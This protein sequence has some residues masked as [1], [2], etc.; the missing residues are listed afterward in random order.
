[1]NQCNAIKLFFYK[2]ASGSLVG[3]Q[4]QDVK[5]RMKVH[6]RSIERSCGLRTDVSEQQLLAGAM[7]VQE[8]SAD[9]GMPG[10]ALCRRPLTSSCFTSSCSEHF[11]L[12]GYH[13]WIRSATCFLLGAAHSSY[14]IYSHRHSVTATGSAKLG[15]AR[16]RVTAVP[17]S[18]RM[19]SCSCEGLT[20][21]RQVASTCTSSSP[22]LTAIDRPAP[23]RSAPR[24]SQISRNDGASQAQFECNSV[25]MQEFERLRQGAGAGAACSA[26]E[27]EK[28]LTE[29]GQ[30]LLSP[31]GLCSFTAWMVYLPRV[32]ELL[33]P[34]TNLTTTPTPLF[35]AWPSSLEGAEEG[36][37]HEREEEED[38]L[39]C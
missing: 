9:H 36:P 26:E 35:C 2:L 12:Y 19:S 7:R 5:R 4:T 6:G 23:T 38:L 29:T 34:L 30:R 3:W 8:T 39:E 18:P 17:G 16:N 32:P 10:R 15:L 31:A 33:R 11:F 14:D 28:A 13:A 1:M 20:P 25:R 22:T 27:P 37:A 21:T 24:L